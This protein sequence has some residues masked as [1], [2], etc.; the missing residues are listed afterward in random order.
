LSAHPLIHQARKRSV[1]IP[2]PL[3][4]RFVLREG[5]FLYLAIAG[6]TYLIMLLFRD[7]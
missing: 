1:F 4:D 6:N 2:Y 3:D 5:M 7:A